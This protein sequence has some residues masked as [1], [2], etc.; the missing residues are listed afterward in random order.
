ML[1][2]EFED[3]PTD[4]S[5]SRS[6]VLQVHYS[7]LERIHFVGKHGELLEQNLPPP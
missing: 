6:L 1:W 3:D 2:N 4:L 5:V 7:V